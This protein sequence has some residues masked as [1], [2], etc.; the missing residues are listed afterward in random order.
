MV[1]VEGVVFGG[2]GEEGGI[3]AGGAGVGSSLEGACGRA[4]VVGVV[5]VGGWRSSGGSRSR[6]CELAC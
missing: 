5:A 4:A 3:D 2:G 1:V 6:G